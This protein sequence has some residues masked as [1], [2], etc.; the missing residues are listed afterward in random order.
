MHDTVKEAEL[1]CQSRSFYALTGIISLFQY[2]K[3][4]KL[5]AIVHKTFL[6]FLGISSFLAA[7]VLMSFTFTFISQSIKRV[8]VFVHDSIVF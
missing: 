7:V 5:S 6:T 4:W 3:I 1:F 8:R 2:V